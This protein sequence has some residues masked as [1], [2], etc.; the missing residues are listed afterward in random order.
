[1]LT[2]ILTYFV[3]PLAT[4]VASILIEKYAPRSLRKI[5]IGSKAVEEFLPIIEK[6]STSNKDLLEFAKAEGLKL[7]ASNIEKYLKIEE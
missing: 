4:G 5:K 3:L 6:A 2:T 7:A 1:M